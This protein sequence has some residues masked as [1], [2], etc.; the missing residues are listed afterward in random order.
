MSTKY[1][2]AKSIVMLMLNNNPNPSDDDISTTVD[3]VL[4]LINTN[5]EDDYVER[6]LLIRD[7]E[8]SCATWS[9]NASVL[10]NPDKHLSWL[11]DKKSKL[12]W[13]FWKRY[14]TYLQ[15]EKSYPEQS[16]YKLDEITDKILEN[17]EDPEREGVWDI[18]GMVVGHVQSGK[19]S[20]YTGLIC[21]AA[22]AGYKFIVVLAGLHK[23][24]RS[25]TQIRLDEGFLG[26]DSR[27]MPGKHVENRRI[28]VGLVKD[29]PEAK[30]LWITNSEDNGDF[31]INVARQIG[32]ALGG[33]P[34]LLVIKKNKTILK[35]LVR[36]AGMDAKED[37]E[38]GK[39]IV[40][41]TPL[42][43]IDDEADNAS[44]NTNP[45]PVDEN[46]KPDEDYDVSA[47]NGE[48]RKLL[49]LFEKKAYVGYTAT[50]FAN[51]FIYPDGE[52]ATHG[53]DLFPRD[54]IINLPTPPNYI[55]SSELFGFN[56]EKE[57]YDGLPIIRMINDFQRFV[58]EKHTK[59]HKPE[60]IPDSLRDAIL[61][62]IITCAARKA[63][64]VRSGHN[65][66]LIHVSRFPAVQK[67]IVDLIKNELGPIKKVIEYSHD[68]S[69]PLMMEMEEI[70]NNDFI[71]TTSSVRSMFKDPLITE[72]SWDS[73]KNHLYES[74][75]KI[76]V[77]EINGTAKDILDY[78]EN[79]SGINVIAVGGEKLSRGLTLEGLSVSYFLR[80]SRMYDTLMQMGRWFGFRPGYVDLCRLYTSHELVEWYRFINLAYEELREE[81]DDMAS[82][83]ATPR[84]FGFR[85]RTHPDNL[86]IT[87]VNKMKSGTEMELSYSNTLVQTA[88]L[89]L[90]ENIL[91]NN[92]RAF[93]DLL[94]RLGTH[95][96][97]SNNHL[98]WEK[99]PPDHILDFI[100]NYMGVE[101]KTAFNTSLI[102]D[103]IQQQNSQ[104]D[105]ELIT[106][107]IVVINKDTK[108]KYCFNGRD[109]GLTTRNPVTPLLKI[110]SIKKGQIIDKKHENLD[111]S[112]FEYNSALRDMREKILGA[113][114][115]IGRYVR[116]N[117]SP[118]KAL[119]LIYPLE[120][121][122]SKGKDDSL[123]VIGMA[124][125]FP[126]SDTALTLRYT[127]T[128]TYWEEEF[129]A[130]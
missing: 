9:G 111:L 91:K 46:G 86:L 98:I 96:R 127:V 87:A 56:N 29:Q 16:I 129:G 49:S 90:D 6:D 8:A 58:P 99:L 93:E 40:R 80:A 43:I 55:G 59:D 22:D 121:P 47:I 50:P 101:S 21:K 44:V 122:S 118:K 84:D 37:T 74:V 11:P 3:Q 83:G 51:I 119:L 81:F 35:N 68:P 117:R 25:Q 48:I 14:A 124:I 60:K 82:S 76:E 39:K 102:L 2:Q 72:V 125:S 41:N 113:E 45:I 57:D 103:Y 30:A 94:F 18:R 33:V 53:D 1:T 23:S 20:N 73:V 79:P 13:N 107:T 75:S 24:L 116:Q 19:T 105:P 114:E 97:C 28:G 88:F 64:G 4:S 123:P 120:N 104:K 85:V 71:P 78:R 95:H 34:V 17:L 62:Y 77:K 32:N 31:K 89:D 70:W 109:I 106:W 52:T 42:L 66:M 100:A 108:N 27:M 112:E 115:P 12:P 69:N 26:F 110:F 92:I 67:K 15:N 36:W 126:K 7:I 128:N 38:T 130:Q 54:F 61:S 65:S 5:A 10:I 63:R